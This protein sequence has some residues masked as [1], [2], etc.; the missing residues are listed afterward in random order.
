MQSL[1]DSRW[2]HLKSIGADRAEFALFSWSMKV[3][4]PTSSSFRY[5]D[6]AFNAHGLTTERVLYLQIGMA[7]CCNYG[8][9]E[10][11]VYYWRLFPSQVRR[12]TSVLTMLQLAGGT[13]RRWSTQL[14]EPARHCCGDWITVQSMRWR[15]DRQTDG[16]V[17]GAIEDAPERTGPPGKTDLPSRRRW[18]TNVALIVTV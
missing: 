2:K 5:S 8:W 14:S 7:K 18:A 1:L 12:R 13:M 11:V 6:R 9:S 16:R 4:L 3:N 10:E 15:T 17:S